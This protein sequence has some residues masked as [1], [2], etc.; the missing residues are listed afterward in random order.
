MR[1]KALANLSKDEPA[2]KA[3]PEC[4]VYMAAPDVQ[5]LPGD[6]RFRKEKTDS[7]RPLSNCFF[8][9]AA[10]ALQQSRHIQKI[11]R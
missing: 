2:T 9:A 11:I 3:E 6:A 5:P 10:H 4:I 1:A 8:D 7:R